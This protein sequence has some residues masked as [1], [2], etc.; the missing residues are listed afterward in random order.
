MSRECVCGKI[1]KNEKGL[2]I[3]QS[4]MKCKERLQASQSTGLVPGETE[5][6]PSPEAPHR[7]Q[8]LQVVQTVPSTRQSEKIRNR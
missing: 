6:E 4:R 2:K 8:S 3:H 1:C 7:A 5:E